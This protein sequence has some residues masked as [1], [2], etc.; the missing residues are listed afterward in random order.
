[1]F[2]VD[3]KTDPLGFLFTTLQAIAPEAWG[4]GDN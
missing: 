4:R 2:N 3:R 1:V